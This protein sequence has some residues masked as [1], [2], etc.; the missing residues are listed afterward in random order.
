MVTTLGTL[1]ASLASHDEAQSVLPIVFNRRAHHL[2]AAPVEARRAKS[3]RW[4]RSRLRGII[5][6]NGSDLLGALKYAVS[7]STKK[8]PA[9]LSVKMSGKSPGNNVRPLAKDHEGV[10]DIVVLTDGAPW[11]GNLQELSGQLMDLVGHMP[12]TRISFVVLGPLSSMSEKIVDLLARNT[13]GVVRAMHDLAGFWD[14]LDAGGDPYISLDLGKIAAE[15]AGYARLT[16]GIGAL[17]RRRSGARYSLIPLSTVP[18]SNDGS[19][20]ISAH[21]FHGGQQRVVETYLPVVI[22]LLPASTSVVIAPWPPL[23]ESEMVPTHSKEAPLWELGLNTGPPSASSSTCQ[24]N[25]CLP[26]RGSFLNFPLLW[27]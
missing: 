4:W 5:Y 8:P 14:D 1:T 16:R 17:D 24:L 6:A 11:S 21:V 26:V 19:R 9:R 20:T 23:G 12:D 18:K 25:R 10:A 15:R 2:L 13:G 27:M 3:A 22:R 7:D